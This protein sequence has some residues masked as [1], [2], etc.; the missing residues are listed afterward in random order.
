MHHGL[1]D[2]KVALAGVHEVKVHLLLPFIDAVV[3]VII[4]CTSR[5]LSALLNVSQLV[6]ELRL[7]GMKVPRIWASLI[8]MKVPRPC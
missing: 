4:V 5:L 6:V 2:V 7:I 3:I 8:G 1:H